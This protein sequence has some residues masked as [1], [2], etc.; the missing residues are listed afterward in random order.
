MEFTVTG[1]EGFQARGRG[2]A[3]VLTS[4]V[5]FLRQLLRTACVRR[6]S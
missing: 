6:V 5:L 3:Y 4:T 2:R 1:A